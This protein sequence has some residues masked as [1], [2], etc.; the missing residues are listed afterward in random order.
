MRRITLLIWLLLVIPFASAYFHEAALAEPGKEA[1]PSKEEYIPPSKSE[2]VPPTYPEKKE[3]PAAYPPNI[4]IPPIALEMCAENEGRCIKNTYQVCRSNTWISI[5]DCTSAERCT[6]LGCVP[7]QQNIDRL[8]C[9]QNVTRSSIKLPP[10]P[11]D[12]R[13][14]DCALIGRGADIERYFSE[15][16]A[17]ARQCRDRLTPM[18]SRAQEAY[19]LVDSQI[20]LLARSRGAICRSRESKVSQPLL[21]PEGEPGSPA[22]PPEDPRRRY[23]T[24]L[25]RIGSNAAEYC[26]RIDEFLNNFATACEGIDN[27]IHNIICGGILRQVSDEQLQE[28]HAQ[29]RSRRGLQQESYT[30]L[31]RFYTET[32]QTTGWGNFREIYNE[33]LLNC[34]PQVT[35]PVEQPVIS[36]P[37]AP[38]QPKPRFAWLRAFFHRLFSWG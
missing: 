35:T 26:G 7:A 36:Q 4:I 9:P 11:F 27:N 34:P 37:P 29:L 13:S 3:P 22:E 23:T 10:L 28:F 1:Y 19:A 20:D 32:L 12:N 17:I 21:L 2:Y 15:L 38:A 14:T 16:E 31:N 25:S 30:E 33:R 5:R 24:W 18:W 8:S 6:P